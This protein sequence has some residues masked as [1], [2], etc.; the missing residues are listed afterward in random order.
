MTRKLLRTMTALSATAAVFTLLLLAAHPVAPAS[1]GPLSVDMAADMAAD[2]GADLD[3][4][5][6]AGVGGASDA[7]ATEGPRQRHLHRARSLLALPYFSFAQG[8]RRTRS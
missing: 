7:E 3:T 5:V 4:G 8:L 1:P 2:V 6:E